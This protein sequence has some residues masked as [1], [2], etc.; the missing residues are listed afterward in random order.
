MI[1]VG[2]L[3]TCAQIAEAAS[4]YLEGALSPTDRACLEQHMLIC[5][6]CDTYIDQMRDTVRATRALA[7]DDQADESVVQALLA[8]YRARGPAR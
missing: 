2:E 1:I 3:P 6:G 8:A 5:D 4:D 7:K